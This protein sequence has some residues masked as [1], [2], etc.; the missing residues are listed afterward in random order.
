MALLQESL[1][2]KQGFPPSGDNSP[3]P[4]SCPAGSSPCRGW[5]RFLRGT[6]G[7][8]WAEP[9]PGLLGAGQHSL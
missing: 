8:I 3:A 5:A 9:E 6:S 7:A 1:G 2:G 4:F